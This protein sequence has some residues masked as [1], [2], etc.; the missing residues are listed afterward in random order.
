MDA[1]MKY[2]EKKHT[3]ID[4]NTDWLFKELGIYDDDPE[5]DKKINEE[6]MKFLQ[7]QGLKKAKII[8]K[9]QEISFH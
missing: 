3:A 1:E 7:Q 2:K 8:I 9:D 5:K 6:L 4:E